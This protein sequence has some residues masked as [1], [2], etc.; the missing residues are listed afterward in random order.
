M[1]RKGVEHKWDCE[2]RYE[3]LGMSAVEERPTGRKRRVKK[4]TPRLP[5]HG[6]FAP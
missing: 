2:D 6:S 5:W 3:V 1:G 4:Y